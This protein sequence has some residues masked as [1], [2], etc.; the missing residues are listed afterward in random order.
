[1][2]NAENLVFTADGNTKDLSQYATKAYLDT[3]ADTTA[4]TALEAKVTA[5]TD[6][7]ANINVSK[8]IPY[9][10][11]VDTYYATDKDLVIKTNNVDRIARFGPN[12]MIDIKY[13]DSA[14]RINPAEVTTINSGNTTFSANPGGITWSSG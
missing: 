7:I 14:I 4:L 12:V 6:A 13:G 2:D 9:D 3:K 8:G 1:V 11:T 5:N 10:A